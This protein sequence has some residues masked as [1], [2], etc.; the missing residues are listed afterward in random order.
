MISLQGGVIDRLSLGPEGRGAWISQVDWM[1]PRHDGVLEPDASQLRPVGPQAAVPNALAGY[2]TTLEWAS[3]R[4]GERIP[5]TIIRA[6]NAAPNSAG[7]VILDGYGCFGTAD[8]PFYWPS[9]AAWLE[10]GGVFVR[11]GMRGGGELGAGW[12][13]A[14]RD[15]NKPAAY[16]DAIDVPNSWPERRD[17]P[18]RIGLTGG[19]CGGM[20][21]G[22]RRSTHHV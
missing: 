16:E 12:H 10:R 21:M 6:A 5:Y 4:D 20:T 19:S 1:V 11:A 2:E 14:G 3:A 18:G 17:A 7:Y 9:L 22:R 13:R 15:R 8:P